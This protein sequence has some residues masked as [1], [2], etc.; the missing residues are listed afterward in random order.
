[1]TPTEHP[2]SRPVE[3]AEVEEPSKLMSIADAISVVQDG[4]H[5]A[6][7]GCLY[8]RTPMALVFELLRQGQTKLTLSRSLTC[9]E[10]ELFLSTGQTTAIETSWMGFGGRWGMSRIMR[11]AVEGGEATFLEYSHLGIAMR[12]RAGAMGVPYVPMRSMLGSDLLARTDAVEVTCPFTNEKLVAVPAVQPDVAII[13]AHRGDDRGNVQIDGYHHMDRD[14][15]RAAKHVIVSVE[16]VVDHEVIMRN[17]DRTVIP[18]FA[19]DAVVEV[20]H[21]AYPHELYGVYDANFDHFD[22]YAERVR[23]H[24]AS[25][26]RG[27]V[28]EYVHQLPDFEA[29]LDTFSVSA[30]DRSHAKTKELI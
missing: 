1:M 24:G 25:G 20:P 7:G 21:G 11:D 22:A 13:H 23:I 16:E 28:T 12:Y 5:I 19:V 2:S 29:F 30:V 27:Y 8:S 26:A 17:P 3:L 9:Y 14:I 10:A 18:H 6:V 4:A 15:A